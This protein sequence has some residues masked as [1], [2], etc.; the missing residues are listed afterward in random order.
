MI[1]DEHKQFFAFAHY[2]GALLSLVWIASFFCYLYGLS[3]PSY[4]L[5]GMLLAVGSPIYAA[6]RLRKFRDNA[7]GGFIGFFRAYYYIINMFFNA[8]ILL[9]VVQ[10]VYYAYFD[11]GYTISC[12]INMMNDETN[13]K[14]IEANGMTDLFNESISRMR[15]MRSFDYMLNSLPLNIILGFILGIPIAGIMYRRNP[16][17]Q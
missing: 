8:A 3:S 15:E 9:G 12:I 16:E 6:Y 2:D 11:N 4:M 1:N 14:I 5:F 7:R 17:Q 13:R 10:I